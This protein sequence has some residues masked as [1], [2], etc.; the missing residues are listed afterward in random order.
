MESQAMDLRF[1]YYM[2]LFGTL[3]LSL[4][5]GGI[6]YQNIVEAPS[7]GTIKD[8]KNHII[9]LARCI[10]ICTIYF[11]L[12]LLPGVIMPIIKYYY[13]GHVLYLVGA[14]LSSLIFP[15]T[16]L[17][18]LKDYDKVKAWR[19]NKNTDID[20]FEIEITNTFLKI[21]RLHTIKAF[22]S[23]LSL[24]LFIIASVIEANEYIDSG[25]LTDK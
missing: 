22:L 1:N 21:K 16:F 5:C 13:G 12:M 2:Q 23:Y 9:N 25:K 10:E 11:P 6:M 15:L 17:F 14:L 4:Y 18:L 8:R 7:M 19:D 24:I 20:Y 3:S